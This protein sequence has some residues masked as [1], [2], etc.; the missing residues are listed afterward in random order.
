MHSKS[1]L[2]YFYSFIHA[3][4]MHFCQ[5]VVAKTSRLDVLKKYFVSKCY[6]IQTIYVTFSLTITKREALRL[7]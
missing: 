7:A 4:L 2:K 1:D 3:N 6:M 5:H